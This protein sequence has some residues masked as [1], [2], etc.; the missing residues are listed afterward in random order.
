MKQLKRQWKLKNKPN[1]TGI[2]FEKNERQPYQK[3]FFG[4]LVTIIIT[5]IG[6]LFVAWLLFN[7]VKVRPTA[8]DYVKSF[9]RIAAE[10]NM[11]ERLN[12]APA[13]G[14]ANVEY[15]LTQYGLSLIVSQDADG[16]LTALVLKTDPAVPV[17]AGWE[18][19]TTA[20][21]R[22]RFLLTLKALDK[23][24]THTLLYSTFDQLGIDLDKPLS[25]HTPGAQTIETE[26]L[27]L[28]LS[29]DQEQFDFSAILDI[30]AE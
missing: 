17:A 5:L 24:W 13:S 19:L 3:G 25:G 12:A 6:I 28:N 8:A 14:E 9:D 26:G 22:D 20:E 18:R 16:Y 1:A 10:Q 30:L 2:N 21:L 27:K 23:S 11:P 4:R 7:P 29:H 15:S